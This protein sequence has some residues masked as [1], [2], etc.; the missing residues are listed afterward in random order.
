MFPT[1]TPHVGRD[2]SSRSTRSNVAVVAV[3]AVLAGLMAGCTAPQSTS[4]RTDPSASARPTLSD[5][6]TPS[7]PPDLADIVV[8]AAEVPVGLNPST[9][10]EGRAVLTRVV[11]SARRLRFTSLTGFAEGRYADFSGDG[12]ILLS[13]AMR[14]DDVAHADQAFDLYLDELESDDG[15]GLDGGTEA[16]LGDEGVCVEGDTPIGVREA[17]CLWRAGTVI[18][19]AGGSI[20]AGKI[21]TIAEGMN[22]RAQ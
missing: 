13:L 22:A 6:P 16:G 2:M 14:F 18:L 1:G 8:T 21:R 12:G 5:L 3:V 9:T 20:G 10:D 4:S 17:I 15:W 11:I 7:A 19:I